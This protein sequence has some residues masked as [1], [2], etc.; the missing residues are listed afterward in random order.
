MRSLKSLKNK[1]DSVWAGLVR[2]RG[3][4]ERCGK[5]DGL[6]AAH[7]VSRRYVATRHLLEN[8]L[9]LCV[10]CHFWAHHN[11]TKFTWWLEE[12]LGKEHLG[13]LHE[14]SQ[15]LSFG[16]TDYERVL[17]YLVGYTVGDK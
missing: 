15:K 17:E 1:C 11:P 9:C 16:K 2:G 6:Q 13:M 4:C 7:I 10:G 14:K 3:K 12:Y 5:R 8:G